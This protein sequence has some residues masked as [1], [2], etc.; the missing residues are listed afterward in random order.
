MFLATKRRLPLLTIFDWVIQFKQR[1]IDNGM[2]NIAFQFDRTKAIETILYLV[3]RMA[4]SDIYGV[5][6]LLY[7]S[8]KTS[9]EKFGRFIFG[10]TYCA[11]KAGATPS[12]TYDLLKEFAQNPIS[13]LKVEG[14]QI[15]ALRDANLDYFSKSDIECLDQ[16][17][18]VWGRVPNW[19]RRL[20]T[21]DDAWQK[22][23]DKKGNKGSVKI[24]VESIAE[25]FDDS[26]DL[27]SYLSNSDNG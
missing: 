27:I 5:C 25:L 22:A 18:D 11:M 21:H 2:S 10:E 7:L 17:I 23:W 13:D 20:A 3:N 14:K 24:P 15:I 8:D 16:I 6:K 1:G 19:S 4:D 26:E 12:N 9:L